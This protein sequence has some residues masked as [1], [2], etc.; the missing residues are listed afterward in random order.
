MHNSPTSIT[1]LL[2]KQH[3]AIHL[4]KHH[5]QPYQQVAAMPQTQ[6]TLNINQTNSRN[7]NLLFKK[8]WD[9]RTL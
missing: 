4:L 8:G 6:A 2:S 7:A 3:V 5:M 9:V 1:H